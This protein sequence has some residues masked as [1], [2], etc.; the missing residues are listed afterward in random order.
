MSS[1]ARL[2]ITA[3][4]FDGASGLLAQALSPIKEFPSLVAVNKEGYTM[5]AEKNPNG[6][7]DVQ[8]PGSTDTGCTASQ[9]ENAESSR[10]DFLKQ[11]ITG[12]TGAV[13]LK[14]LNP[15]L[16]FRSRVN[17]KSWSCFS[18]LDQNL[19]VFIVLLR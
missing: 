5:S 12:A 10:R 6:E 9:P 18:L 19:I 13:S 2:L 1:G 3:L 16:L 11:S 7:T 17:G 15:F 4:P 14:Q 8:N